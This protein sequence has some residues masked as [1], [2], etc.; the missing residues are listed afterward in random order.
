MYASKVEVTLRGY[1]GDVG[2]YPL[3][4]AELVYLGGGLR[5]VYGCQHHVGAI[6]MMGFEL[7]VDMVDLF[8]FY[9]IS[10]LVVEALSWADDRDVG[11]GVEDIDDAPSSYLLYG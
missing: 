10:Y 8:L 2:R 4:L 9:P 1:V 6:E 7:A 3:L 11:V 5:V